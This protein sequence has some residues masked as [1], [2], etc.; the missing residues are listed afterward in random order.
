MAIVKDKT[1]RGGE[2]H[3]PKTQVLILFSHSILM[4][5]AFSSMLENAVCL[6]ELALKYAQGIL[7]NH[8]ST[9]KENS[10][11]RFVTLQFRSCY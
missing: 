5:Q 4:G 11:T 10:R 2:R 7:E 8:C 9:E 3:R 1:C 6:S